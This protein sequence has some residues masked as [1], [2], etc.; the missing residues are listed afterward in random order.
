MKQ[1]EET[2]LQKGQLFIFLFQH[3][4]YGIFNQFRFHAIRLEQDN[5]R[6]VVRLSNLSAS[7]PRAFAAPKISRFGFEIAMT[8]EDESML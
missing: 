3:P 8:G 7:A 5:F 4:V 1:N 6:F 2:R